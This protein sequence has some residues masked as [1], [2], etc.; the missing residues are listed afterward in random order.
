MNNALRR[1]LAALTAAAA[2]ATIAVACTPKPA[3]AAETAN[4]S[5]ALAVTTLQAVEASG[6][7]PVLRLPARTM[8]KGE[9]ILLTARLAG[10]SNATM[11]PRMAVRLDAISG[12]TI[13]RSPVKSINHDGKA[14]GVQ[15]VALRWLL[16]APVDGTYAITMRGE[17]T[18]YL[19]TAT[20]RLTIDPAMTYLKA[21]TVGQKSIQWGETAEDCVGRV[22]H[23]APDVAACKTKRTSTSALPKTITRPTGVKAVTVVGD[24]ELSR[25]Y[26]S[27]PGGSSKVNV[28]LTVNVRTSTGKVCATKTVTKTGL[29][30]TSRKHHFHQQLTASSVPTTCGG[31]ITTAVKVTHVSGNPVGIHG[32]KESNGIAL[33]G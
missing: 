26:G 13:L 28:S 30:I 32:E 27:Y 9:R 11:Y 20:T 10:T 22:N 1:T 12:A 23:P 31:K 17:A 18:T 7:T 25:E 8:A 2:A 14:Y 4:Y 16:T 6:L 29:V 21:S 33:M 15:A 3:N 5:T 24:V 19:N